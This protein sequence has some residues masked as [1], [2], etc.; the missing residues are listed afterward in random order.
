MG[1]SNALDYFSA[2]ISNNFK[3]AYTFPCIPY[4]QYSPLSH[5]AVHYSAYSPH[6]LKLSSFMSPSKL[7]CL[8]LSP[9][10]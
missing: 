9:F 3:S 2:S 5:S 10:A 4:K 8:E 1:A 6:H 7:R